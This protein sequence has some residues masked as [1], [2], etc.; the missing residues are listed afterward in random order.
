MHIDTRFIHAGGR[1]D[2]ETGALAPP[3]HLSTT[4]ERAVDGQP[5]HGFS[6]IRD[7]NPTQ[8][9]LEEALAAIDSAAAALFFGSGMAAG[10]ALLQALPLQLS[11]SQNPLH[12]HYRR[13][14][15]RA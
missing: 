4:F 3:L 14:R 8:A 10:A 7:G 13:G 6:Y 12:L 2:E 11:A 5:S 15:P 9:R 1:R